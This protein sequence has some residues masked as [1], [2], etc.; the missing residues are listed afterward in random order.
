M[1]HA[2][3]HI[4]PLKKPEWLRVRAPSGEEYNRLKQ[5]ITKERLHTVCES[6]SCP[7]IGECWNLG[8]ATFMILGNTCTRAC[9]F[10]HVDS[11]SRPRPVDLDEPKRLADTVEKMKLKHIVITSVTRDD[12]PDGGAKHF[13]NCITAIRERVPNVTIEIL[14]PDF[15]LDTRAIDVVL[16]AKPEVFNHNVETVER[17]TPKIRSGAKFDRSLKVLEYVK[18]VSPRTK[19]KSGIMLGLGETNEEVKETIVALRKHQVDLL[20]IGQY[21]QPTPWYH[22]VMRYASPDEFRELGEFAKS[23]G[24]SHVES[25]PLV[26]SSYHAEKGVIQKH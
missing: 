12:L 14:T 13:Y 1:T 7:N 20:T 15:Q 19:T 25:G 26:R 9:R 2:Q 16:S 23:L 21:L 8:T 6:A 22:P 17:L 3:P 11:S 24:F 4:Q 18:S 5:L 10:C